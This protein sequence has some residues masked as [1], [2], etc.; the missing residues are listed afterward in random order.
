MKGCHRLPLRAQLSAADP[1]RLQG[2]L[3][4]TADDIPQQQRKLSLQGGQSSVPGPGDSSARGGYQIT[5]M[6]CSYKVVRGAAS[7]FRFPAAGG[8]LEL[9][10][11]LPH[12]LA[13][14][15]DGSHVTA[16]VAVVGRRE[17]GH[18]VLFVAP[19]VPLH[20]QLV[21]PRH[22]VQPVCVVE[23][24]ADVLTEGVA[25]ASGGNAPATPVVWI[26][27]QQVAH[28]P[29]VRYLLHT[30][31]SSDVIQGVQRRRQPP[32]Q[33]EDLTLHQGSQGQVVKQIS[34][35]LPDVGIPVLPQALIIEPIHLRNLPALVIAS[36][37]GDSV[38][39]PHLQRNQQTGSLH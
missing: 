33:A 3:A 13:D 16:A 39:I 9:Q 5:A 17:D 37:D 24:F 25:C 35:A 2:I 34:E 12:R 4:A 29:F 11:A 21:R 36:Q 32:V 15:H 23:L 6:L 30:V 18:H 1:P 19:V 22:Q 20:Y 38:P 31:Q 27:P 26:A 28:G 8:R 7:D 14:L 10:E